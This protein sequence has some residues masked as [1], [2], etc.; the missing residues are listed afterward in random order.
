M[1]A[2]DAWTNELL[3]GL[4]WQ[5]PLD[6]TQEQLTYTR[7]AD[8]AQF[9]PDRFPVW[10]WMDEPSWYGFP[11]FGEPRLGQDRAGLRRARS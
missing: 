6:V 8:L 4:D 5:V 11:E 1:L 10:I 7:P 3:A 2:A 9:A